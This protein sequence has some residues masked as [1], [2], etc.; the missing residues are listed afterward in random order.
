MAVFH[1]PHHDAVC[2]GGLGHQRIHGKR[3]LGK[4]R[5]GT[6]GQKGVGNEFQ[7]VVRAIAQHDA[8]LCH[9]KGFGDFG[10]EGK[11]VAIRVTRQLLYGGQYGGTGFAA[12][13]QRVLVRGE[14]NDTG[15]V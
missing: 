13:A 9:A 1:R 5:A 15:F 3:I 11:A 8:V 10:F 14:F 2:A 6:W 7:H 12:H 4:H